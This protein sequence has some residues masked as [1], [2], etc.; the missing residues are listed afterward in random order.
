MFL[1]IFIKLISKISSDDSVNSSTT[2]HS[3]LFKIIVFGSKKC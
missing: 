3:N 1:D 2:I